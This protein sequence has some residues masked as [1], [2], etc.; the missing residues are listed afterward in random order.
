MSNKDVNKIENGS[1]NDSVNAVVNESKP[2]AGSLKPY[3]TRLN[4]PPK[5]TYHSDKESMVFESPNEIKSPQEIMDLYGMYSRDT[6]MFPNNELVPQYG[7][8]ASFKNFED[9]ANLVADC[10]Q[11]FDALPSEVRSKFDN[12]I[13]KFAEYVNSEDFDYEHVMSDGYKQKVWYPMKEKLETE[14]KL[15]MEEFDYKQYLYRKSKEEIKKMKLE[16][17][18]PAE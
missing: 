12:D 5:I 9:R 17:E 2:T 14:A 4:L 18:N 8:F 3:F 15:K 11:Q 13:F 16:K 1:I 10:R 6:S 7:D